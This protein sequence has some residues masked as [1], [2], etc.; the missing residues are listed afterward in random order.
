MSHFLHS[1]VC[2]WILRKFH[3]CICKQGFNEYG[4]ID[5]S[6]NPF[7]VSI[8]TVQTGLRRHSIVIFPGIFLMISED[9]YLLVFHILVF[10]MSAQVIFATE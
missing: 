1:F 10:K 6:C 4:N 7:V 5:S 3:I 9:E 2:Q 8:I